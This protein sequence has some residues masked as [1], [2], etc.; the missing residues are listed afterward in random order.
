MGDILHSLIKSG[1]CV[2]FKNTFSK[3]AEKSLKRAGLLHI[4]RPLNSS[5]YIIKQTAILFITLYLNEHS[6]FVNKEL[7]TL[8][9][10][11]HSK[12]IY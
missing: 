12:D 6:L 9:S 2:G 1:S 7:M 3:T 11:P 10:F 8:Y 5:F 4:T